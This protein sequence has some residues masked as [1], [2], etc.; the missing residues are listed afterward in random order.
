M[1]RIG[2]SRRLRIDR[3]ASAYAEVSVVGLY[4]QRAAYHRYSFTQSRQPGTEHRRILELRSKPVVADL[5]GHPAVV[6]SDLDVALPGAGVPECVGH[7]FTDYPPG[8]LV[9]RTRKP[10]GWK[11]HGG[12]QPCGPQ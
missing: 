3:N 6:A 12:P 5:D 11:P 4:R 9:D 2:S 7:G 8:T 1:R 10:I